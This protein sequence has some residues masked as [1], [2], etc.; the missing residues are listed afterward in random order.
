MYK[1]THKKNFLNFFFFFLK[2]FGLKLL[3]FIIYQI[4]NNK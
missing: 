3:L 2:Y 1:N 4:I